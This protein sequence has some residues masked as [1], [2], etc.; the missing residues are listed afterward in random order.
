MPNVQI[1]VEIPPETRLVFKRAC[2]D[3]GVTMSDVLRRAIDEAIL[4][5]SDIA[6]ERDLEALRAEQEAGNG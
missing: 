6:T 4:L 5:V 2:L 1:T 3:L